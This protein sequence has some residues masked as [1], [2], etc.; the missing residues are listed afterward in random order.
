LADGVDPRQELARLIVESNDFAK[1]AV[2]RLWAQLFDYG[3]TRPVDDLG[4]QSAAVAPAVLDRLATEFAAHD[5]DVKRLL[6]WAVL[7]D[8]FRRS[9]QVTDLASKDMPEE[10][11]RALFSRFY[12]RPSRAPAVMGA[13][14]EAGRIRTKGG[15]RGE[16]EKA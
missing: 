16:V 10:G 3:F 15:S 5:F 13:L 2:N 1:A 12:N 14:V 8:A 11:E 9:A 7:S 6:R 4:P